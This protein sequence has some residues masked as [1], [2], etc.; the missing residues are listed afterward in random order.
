MEEKNAIVIK[1]EKTPL[2]MLDRENTLSID[3]AAELVNSFDLVQEIMRK[4]SGD[5]RTEDVLDED[6]HKIGQR[7]HV[8]PQLLKWHQEARHTLETMWKLGGG[9]IQHEAEKKK[10]EIKANL[11][12]KLLGKSKKEREEMIEDWKSSVSFKQ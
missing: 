1:K 6:D 4:L 5:T 8:H 2:D 3:V 11:I 7:T 10:L 9:E 12:M